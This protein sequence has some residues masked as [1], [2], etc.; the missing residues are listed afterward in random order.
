M[1]KTLIIW[2]YF[3]EADLI[4]TYLVDSD[5][6]AAQLARE[7]LVW[8]PEVVASG[9]EIGDDGRLASLQFAIYCLDPLSDGQAEAQIPEAPVSLIIL[10]F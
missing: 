6:V 2:R 7:A 8:M 1:K 5:S 9:D 10:D 4:R 3:D